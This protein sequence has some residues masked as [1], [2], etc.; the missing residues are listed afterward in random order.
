MTHIIAVL[1][2][3]QVAQAFNSALTASAHSCCGG[4]PGRSDSK[5]LI[6]RPTRFAH[7]WLAR[8]VDFFTSIIARTANMAAAMVGADSAPCIGFT[9][10]SR[11]RDKLTV[12]NEAPARQ[13]RSFYRGCD[14]A[15][16]LDETS[17]QGYWQLS[18]VA[19]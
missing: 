5:S 1:H 7:L 13:K 3:P 18:Q 6:A 10:Y 14:I 2:R 15:P 19:A 9:P 12:Q 8:S 4:A 16:R 11:P 17:G